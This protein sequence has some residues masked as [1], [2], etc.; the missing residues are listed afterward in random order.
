MPKFCHS[1][2]SAMVCQSAFNQTR[3]V[4][5][6]ASHSSST[7]Q[8]V[9]GALL[10]LT[11]PQHKT[12]HFK[13][14]WLICV[15]RRTVL[16]RALCVVWSALLNCYSPVWPLFGF[17]HG[18]PRGLHTAKASR[19]SQGI[20]ERLT[21]QPGCSHRDSTNAQ[22]R[23]FQL[24]SHGQAHS[25][26]SEWQGGELMEIDTMMATDMWE[27][28]RG[29]PYPDNSPDTLQLILKHLHLFVFE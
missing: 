10:S 27:R 22:V 7:Q 25:K 28:N 26:A 1:N 19:S 9:T 3:C 20:N 21:V 12:I 18:S 2:L 24:N 11:F 14:S 13:L 17:T 4:W 8:A 6:P 29:V 16:N 23:P 15:W 5:L